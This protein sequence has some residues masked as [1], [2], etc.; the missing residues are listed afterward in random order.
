MVLVDLEYWYLGCC[1][2]FDKQIED[3]DEN[4]AVDCMHTRRAGED[5]V[6]IDRTEEDTEDVAVAKEMVVEPLDMDC[7]ELVFDQMLPKLVLA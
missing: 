3:V 5:I 4:I 1:H 7:S 6:G 2:S